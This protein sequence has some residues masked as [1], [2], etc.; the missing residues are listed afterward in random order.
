MTD[1]T[2]KTAI[3]RKQNDEFRSKTGIPVFAPKVQGQ[4]LM[5][6]GISQLPPE[7]IIA[8][9][10]KVR[11][12]S[13]FSEGNDPYAEHDFGAFDHG[14]KKVFWKIDY[15]DPSLSYGSDAPD[16]AEAT[17]RVCT[18]EILQTHRRRRWSDD[19]RRSRL[20]PA[21]FARMFGRP[22]GSPGSVR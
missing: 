21:D 15:Y 3:I 17:S 11:D 7:D 8:V 1:T 4:M 2:D 19:A 18:G 12:F 5:T 16:N 9:W 10:A 6:P 14:G 13:D 20:R 22:A